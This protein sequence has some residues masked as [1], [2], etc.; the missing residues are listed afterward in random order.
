MTESRTTIEHPPTEIPIPSIEKYPVLQALLNRDVMFDGTPVKI[1]RER[2]MRF[3]PEQPLSDQE[4]QKAEEIIAIKQKYVNVRDAA[5]SKKIYKFRVRWE[6]VTKGPNVGQVT[7]SIAYKKK[8][9]GNEK[10]TIKTA[11]DQ[12]EHKVEFKPTDALASTFNELWALTVKEF[13]HVV[14]KDRYCFDHVLGNSGV[15]HIH[16]DVHRAPPE[17]LNGRPRAEVEFDNE[18]DV[19]FVRERG[20]E[21]TLPAYLGQ[22]VTLFQGFK[23]TAIARTGSFPAE[24][25]KKK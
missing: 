8:V 3:L 20:V 6:R 25:P 9:E 5:D 22:D 2:E 10:K 1:E 12:W 7:L 15:A 17:A 21:G 11:G 13:P 24:L 19:Q 14:Y 16:Y 4:L 18:T 23:S